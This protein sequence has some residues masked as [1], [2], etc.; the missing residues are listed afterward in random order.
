MAGIGLVYSYVAISLGTIPP[1]R[2]IFGHTLGIIG[3]L[4]MLMTETLYSMRKR[5]R[6]A[7]WGRMASWLKF[8]IYTGLVGP[9]LVLLHSSW[10]FNGLAGIVL[11]LTI[12]IVFSGF[13]GRYIYT[14]VPRTAE[15]I[16]VERDVLVAQIRENEQKLQLWMARQPQEIQQAGLR[17][18]TI[19]PSDSTIM[20]VLGRFVFDLELRIRFFQEKQHIREEYK[21]QVQQLGVLVKQKQKLQGQ[22]NGLAQARRLL[23]FWHAVHVPLG[24]TLFTT[25]F[26]HI[27]AAI[28]YATLLH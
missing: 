7:H 17:L 11:L 15:G 4:L 6:F 3:F 16:L 27:M 10:K 9:F 14:A 5:T 19:P 20:S 1:A 18:A 12:I 13:I 22:I 23:S 2:E 21:L 26:I 28:Y 24:I 8:H 25:A